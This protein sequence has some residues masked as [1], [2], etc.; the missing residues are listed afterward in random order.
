ML[1]VLVGN[2][3]YRLFSKLV[4]WEVRR[5]GPGDLCS[6]DLWLE[7]RTMMLGVGIAIV[8]S[9]VFCCMRDLELVFGGAVSEGL[10]SW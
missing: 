9:D 8:K 6:C 3:R 2:P 7:V 4:V 10:V 5:V 1:V